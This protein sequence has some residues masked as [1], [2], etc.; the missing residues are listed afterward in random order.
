VT[1]TTRDQVKGSNSIFKL[2]LVEGFIYIAKQSS[3]IEVMQITN[4]KQNDD[5]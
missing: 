2:E 4:Y 1:L 3:G 5:K